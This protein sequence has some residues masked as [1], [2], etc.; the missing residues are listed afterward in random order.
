MGQILHAR[1][2]MECSAL[3][4]HLYRK[5]LFQAPRAHVATLR[6]HITSFSYVQIIPMQ[7]IYIFRVI[8]TT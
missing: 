7:E 5:I 6:A 2:R 3:N 1:I 8:L 4:S